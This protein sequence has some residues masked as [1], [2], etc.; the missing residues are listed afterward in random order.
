MEW[1]RGIA[2]NLWAL[3]K[4]LRERLEPREAEQAYGGAGG[5]VDPCRLLLPDKPPQ[6]VAGVVMTVMQQA[7]VAAC[8]I[9][10]VYPFCKLLAEGWAWDD[11]V[12]HVVAREK[13]PILLQGETFVHTSCIKGR[14]HTIAFYGGVD[15]AVEKRPGWEEL[16]FP[17]HVEVDLEGSLSVAGEQRG[18]R[19]PRALHGPADGLLVGF[20][21]LTGVAVAASWLGDGDALARLT[22]AICWVVEQPLEERTK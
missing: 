4:E 15:N 19:H 21:L 6:C 22:R 14:L 12:P 3:T 1:L 2:R 10:A 9:T 20:L 18:I 8:C 11:L 13:S 16:V 17:V 7:A 5:L